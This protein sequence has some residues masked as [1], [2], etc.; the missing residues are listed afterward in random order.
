MKTL[1][2]TVCILFVIAAAGYGIM[3]TRTGSDEMKPVSTKEEQVT[4]VGRTLDLSNQG[5]TKVPAYVFD[6]TDIET[7][8]LSNNALE[9]AIQAEVCHLQN[10]KVLNLSNNSFTGV[11]AEIGQ[12]KNLEVLDLSNNNITGLPYELSNLSKLRL[13]VLKGNTYSKADLA[14]IKASLPASTVVQTD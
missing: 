3:V 12:L 5:L 7:L 9:G 1:L 2:V 13:L 10:L 8:N 6:R 11:P 14:K 4:S